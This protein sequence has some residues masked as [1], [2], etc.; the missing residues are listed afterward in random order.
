MTDWKIFKEELV[1]RLIDIPLPTTLTTDDDFQT[2]VES[3]TSTLQDV[4]RTTVPVSRPCPHSKKWWNKELSDLKKRKNKLS[5]ISYKFRAIPD[6]PSHE[7]HKAVRNQYGDAIVKAKE[8]HWVDFLEDVEERELWIANKFISNPSGDG[9]K[10]R[11]P[12]LKVK[13]PDNS[14]SVITS[15]EGKAKILSKQFFPPTPT[16]STV[17]ANHSSPRRVPMPNSITANQIKRVIAKLSPYKAYGPDKIPNIILIKCTDLIID[18][19]V[20]IF[21]AVFTLKTYSD[22]WKKSFTAVLRKPGKP[23]YNI[24]KAYR[25]IALLNTIAKV[26]TGVLAEDLS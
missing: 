3:L 19:L 2:A 16:T 7:Q 13:L 6:H 21:I 11:I 18:Y 8:Q 1:A 15:N 20:E 17:P 12:S 23:C 22:G 25:L 14:I 9:S 4:I 24:P 5:G 10:S 26:L